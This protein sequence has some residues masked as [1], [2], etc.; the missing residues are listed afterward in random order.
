MGDAKYTAGDGLNLLKMAG[1]SLPNSELVMFE[2]EFNKIYDSS[3]KGYNFIETVWR[4]YSKILPVEAYPADEGDSDLR[5]LI[6]D[7]TF[8]EKIIDSGISKKISSGISLD[9]IARNLGI[10]SFS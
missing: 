1:I 10:N 3:G 6:R 7:R 5:S 9:N 8:Q 2:N 4:V